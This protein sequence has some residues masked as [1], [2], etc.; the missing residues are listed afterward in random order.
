MRRGSWLL[1]GSTL[2]VAAAFTVIA[3]FWSNRPAAAVSLEIAGALVWAV[4]G[5]AASRIRPDSRIG[6]LMQF[7]GLIL[8]L[9]LPDLFLLDPRE[10]AQAAL[11][12]FGRS[13]SEVQFAVVGHVLLAYPTGILAGR[14]TRSLV[15]I[16]YAYALAITPIMILLPILSGDVC[17][18]GCASRTQPPEGGGLIDGIDR[19]VWVVLASAAMVQLVRRTVRADGRERRIL[20]YPVVAIAVSISNF[21]V[22]EVLHPASDATLGRATNLAMPALAAAAVPVAF[23]AGL[24]RD[25]VGYRASAR[26]LGLIERA[27][28]E[29]LQTA[30]RDALGDSGLR[31]A[32]P[33]GE[34][35]HVDQRGQPLPPESVTGQAVLCVGD[36]GN[37]Q[38]VAVIV[39]DPSLREKPELLATLTTA[40]GFAVDNARL[41]ALNRA[42]LEEIHASRRRL[43]AA[44]DD[45]RRRLERDLHDG[46]QQ[47]LVGLGIALQ[48]LT[49]QLPGADRATKELLE[50]IDGELH[51]AINELR[52]LANGIHPAV[53]TD[54]GLGPAVS[55]LVQRIRIPVAVTVRLPHRPLPEV[56][57]T[58]YFVLSECLVNSVKHAAARSISVQL[59]H[60][61]EMV[62]LSAADDG[63]GGADPSGGTG[64]RGLF[65]RAAAADGKLRIISPPGGGTRI[66]LELPCV[67]SL[68]TTAS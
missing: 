3:L 66:E 33:T 53:L 22:H 35:G 15:R 18:G 14:V 30:L 41:L 4:T 7:A 24:L 13:F 57:A 55:A 10:P 27:S 60:R 8:T 51:A 49:A 44:A 1:L 42:H 54:H 46:A 58:A 6:P 36:D 37:G 2:A 5:W 28:P 16:A 34:G 62:C 45:E 64:L 26:L 48:M 17:L 59:S 65:D 63:G 39:H 40:V 67:C 38:P 9:N 11:I 23:L 43:V 31:L 50:E 21:I 29:D 68:S 52:D 12:L 32:F 25:R 20:A 56:E 19:V 61:D 47:R